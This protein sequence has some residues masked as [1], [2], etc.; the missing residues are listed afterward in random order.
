LKRE[1]TRIVGLCILASVAF[2]I[3]HD[4]LSVQACLEYFTVYHP[5]VFA[6]QN[7][8]LLALLWGVYAAWWMGLILGLP[9]AV[10]CTRGNGPPVTARRLAHPL[11]W[12]LAALLL[13]SLLTW[14]GVYLLTTYLPMTLD[15][16]N[17]RPI[18][19]VNRRLAASAIAHGLAYSG[20]VV[21]G[22]GL[23]IWAHRSRK[24]LQD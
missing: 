9:L 4:L 13:A 17:N 24:V 15:P 19:E 2:G 5:P 18:P 6:T 16:V 8:W 14:V 1:D 21:I 23:M 3:A 12:S 10:F 20:S 11:A 22:V 7:P